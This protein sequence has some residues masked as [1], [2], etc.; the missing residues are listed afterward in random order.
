MLNYKRG[1]DNCHAQSMCQND[2]SY[3]EDE[4]YVLWRVMSQIDPIMRLSIQDLVVAMCKVQV[5]RIETLS[6]TVYMYTVYT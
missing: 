2:A 1:I 6:H 4:L 3:D 5:S